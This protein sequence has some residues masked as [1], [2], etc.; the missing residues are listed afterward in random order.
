MSKLR[1]ATCLL[2]TAGLMDAAYLTYLKLSLMNQGPGCA[3]D[4]C[5]LVNQSTYAEFLGVPVALWGF[6]AYGLVLGLALLWYD[7]RGKWQS[8]VGWAI[9]AVSG[10]GVL[11][12]AY[13]TAVEVLVLHAVCPF[14]LIS[15][16]LMVAIFAVAVAEMSGIPSMRRGHPSDAP[17]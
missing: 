2:A 14:C 15:A 11:F 3:F 9:V 8:R 10:W 1:L 6:V 12:S 5:D 4:G 17:A 16:G 13:L 7:A